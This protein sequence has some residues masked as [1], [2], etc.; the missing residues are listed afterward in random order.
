[1]NNKYFIGCFNGIKEYRL[2]NGLQVLLIEDYSRQ[3]ITVHMTYLVGSRHEGLGETGMAHLLEHMLFKKTIHIKDIKF[4]LHSKGALF[5]ASTW[6]DRTNYYETLPYND[7]N[8]EFAISLEADRMMNCIITQEDL[9]S[10]I[11][12][13][14]NELEMCE[15]CPETVLHDHVMSTAF[16]W[17]NYGKSTIGNKYDIKNASVQLLY[18]FYKKYYQPD[19]AALVISGHFK[20]INALKLINSYFSHI[21]KPDRKLNII[22]TR[23][24]AQEGNKDINIFRAGTISIIC[25]GYHIPNGSNIDFI[26]LKIFLEAMIYEPSGQLYKELVITNIADYVFGMAHALYDP[27]MLLFF[28]QTKN[29]NQILHMKEKLISCIEKYDD[30]IIKD[31]IQ[32]IKYNLLKNIKFILSNTKKLTSCLSE[33][34]AQGNYKLFFWYKD[35]VRHITSNDVLH[36]IKKYLIPSN[37]TVGV[38]IPKNKNNIININKDTAVI[39]QCNNIIYHNHINDNNIIFNANN[40]HKYNQIITLSNK[41]ALSLLHKSTRENLVYMK[42]NFY[43]GNEESI[44]NH[45]EENLLLPK[46]FLRG[47]KNKS[48]QQIKEYLDQLE[49]SIDFESSIGVVSANIIS[50]KKNVILVLKL[51][52]DIISNTLFSYNDFLLLRNQAISKLMK[53]LSHVETMCFNALSKSINPCS[54]NSIHYIPSLLERVN[55]LKTLTVDNI[56]KFYKLN[57]NFHNIKVSV[58]GSFDERKIIAFFNN[59]IILNSPCV[60]K[61]I[62]DKF[63]KFDNQD[64]LIKFDDK[65]MSFV[66]LA[67]KIKIR[68]YD[69][70]YAALKIAHYI[71]GESI[72]SRLIYK[73]RE[74]EGLS[75]NIGSQLSSSKFEQCSIITIHA[76]ASNHTASKVLKLIKNELSQWVHY[77]ISQDELDSAKL[78]FNALIT[79][80][81]NNNKILANMLVD[82]LYANQTFILYKNL[83]EKIHLLNKDNVNSTIK[84]IFKNYTISSIIGGNI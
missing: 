61:R 68:E 83:L 65:Q 31:N 17:H 38:F 37:R 1:M 4:L 55:L 25:I 13:V 57:F 71:F 58:V 78:S 46:F 54:K 51:L 45:V 44:L 63:I 67:T 20:D 34:I 62:K 28:A 3:D 69:D 48:Y 40:L 39:N 36:N 24:P 10:E 12:V 2:N 77:G 53:N 73:I 21:K 56:Y 60:Y 52:F 19:N 33:Y 14:I 82:N 6:F 64:Q 49:S 79:N 7:N 16:Q 70:D 15:N 23:E 18:S 5:N 84:K 30:N 50:D 59:I 47:T 80:L 11:K 66:V 43:C 8:L 81:L 75:Y 26:R 42:I 35:I 72:N 76:M 41:V 74:T 32:K 29:I 9:N 22:Y 27:S